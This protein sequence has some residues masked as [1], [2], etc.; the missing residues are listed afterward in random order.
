MIEQAWADY[1]L[2]KREADGPKPT[3][4]GT[5]NRC[6]DAGGCVR[7]LWFAAAGTPETEQIES[8]TLL[9]FE[10]GTAIHEALQEA[11]LA[12][13]PD[14]E[15]ERP[16]DLSKFGVSLSGHCDGIVEHD[17]VKAVLEFK[18]VGSYAAKLAWGEDQPKREHVA[19]AAMYAVG[20]DA[21]A[22]RLVYVAKE[23][24]WRAKIKPGDMREWEYG[25]DEITP[26]AATPRELAQIEFDRFSEVQVNLAEGWVPAA[27]APNN[28]GDLEAVT[29]VAPYG[30]P[31]KGH[32]YWGCR[33]CRWNSVCA[34][35]GPT[36]IPVEQLGELS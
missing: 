32:P 8:G 27:Y 10:V 9:A 22:V 13:W 14:A 15:I 24:D 20:V 26:H 33:Y 4:A 25:V 34:A 30:V 16:I 6:S 1:M 11:V 7:A 3:A 19:Q 29:S 5:L 17:G 35:C 12:G 23:G 18:T 31:S 21:D 2:A 28:A 36:M